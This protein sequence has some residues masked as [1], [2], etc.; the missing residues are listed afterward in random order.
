[1][2]ITCEFC[3]NLY[4]DTNAT[5]PNCGAANPCVRKETFDNPTTIEGLKKWY[6]AMNLPPYETTRFFIGINYKERRAFGIYKD[7]NTGNFVVYKNKDDG[8]RAIRYEG[9]DEAFAVNELLTRLK[10]EILHQKSGASSA[11]YEASAKRGGR[12]IKIF[13]IVFG[14]MI[15]TSTAT[16]IGAFALF[17]IMANLV[18]ST[19][20]I[21][22]AVNAQTRRELRVHG[23]V[24]IHEDGG[25]DR[26]CQAGVPCVH[27]E[28]HRPY[29]E[30]RYG[31]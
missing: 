22:T 31:H 3:G 10:Q 28:A 11:A 17:F 2:K 21:K 25:S 26:I 4:D 16:W 13:G 8:S 19:I 15:L 6:E 7:E 30:Y 18:L 12:L 23:Y 20:I 29:G 27:G 24:R 1:M 5:C 9:T 14:L